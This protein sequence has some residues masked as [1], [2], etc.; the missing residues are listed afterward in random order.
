MALPDENVGK[1]EEYLDS[2]DT[3]LKPRTPDQAPDP[4]PQKEFNPDLVPERQDPEMPDEIGSD[5]TEEVT[6]EADLLRTLTDGKYENVDDLV[7]DYK[8]RTTQIDELGERLRAAGYSVSDNPVQDLM[9]ALEQ[10]EMAK[11]PGF[12]TGA[13]PPEKVVPPGGGTTYAQPQSPRPGEGSYYNTANFIAKYPQLRWTPEFIK[14]LTTA[15]GEHA[16]QP[17]M[18]GYTTRQDV[19]ALAK[20]NQRL[21]RDQMVNDHLLQR[22]SDGEKIPKNY[23][24]Q[25]VAEIDKNPALLERAWRGY[26]LRGQ[27]NGVVDDYARSVQ[28]G[29]DPNTG[30]S[31]AEATAQAREAQKVISARKVSTGGTPPQVAGKPRAKSLRDL[32]KDIEAVGR[33]LL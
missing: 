1:E 21:F 22:M 31:R 8:S 7:T 3:D 33:K 13:Q 14:E 5:V 2:F 27:Y 25:L 20:L 30:L 6:D 32:E 16:A 24:S 28:A 10:Q 12:L 18:D 29:R 17:Q 19:E 11:Y 4:E 15:M 23:R 9:D 26:V